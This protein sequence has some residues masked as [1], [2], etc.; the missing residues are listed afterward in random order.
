MNEELL[1]GDP[2]VDIGHIILQKVVAEK[3]YGKTQSE[4]PE[5]L[6]ALDW[7][8]GLYIN[9]WQKKLH[10]FF[11]NSG[12][13]NPSNSGKE[14]EK[15]KAEYERYFRKQTPDA[16]GICR[17]AGKE[18]A[19]YA[20][21][22]E[23][24]ILSG[25]GAFINFHHSLEGGLMTGGEALFATFFTPLGCVQAGD[26][27]ALI[28]SNR[29][30]VTAYLAAENYKLNTNPAL[31]GLEPGLAKV[32]AGNPAN[33]I[34]EYADKINLEK[35]RFG[36]AEDS[37]VALTLYHFTNF[38]AKPEVV[39][40]NLSATL[41]SFYHVVTT[42]PEFQKEWNFFVRDHYRNSKF[43]GAKA[44][45]DNET[46]LVPG[47]EGATEKVARDTY[48]GWYNDV[49]RNLIANQNL[50]PL[51][52]RWTQ[53]RGF[54]LPFKIISYYCKKILFMEQQTLNLI[55]RLAKHLAE[56]DESQV[57]KTLNRLKLARNEAGVRTLL[58]NTQFRH[59]KV[60]QKNDEDSVNG[61]DAEP[62]IRLEEYVRYLFPESG[63][64]RRIKDL[65]LI[66]I[67]EQL[68]DLGKAIPVLD[69]ETEKDSYGNDGE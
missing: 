44:T 43:K 65:L 67:Y 37:A 33:A 45:A 16:R 17:V 24:V 2:F 58:L 8:S 26:K 53:K 21:G 46:L 68:H 63:D 19:L 48:Q 18:D 42:Y 38:G 29:A 22:R 12:I 10:G 5:E 30:D 3:P 27:I 14:A 4:Q 54:I 49:Y 55:E 36:I 7:A 31:K 41:F 60:Q 28:H 64:W 69:E 25:S 6:N 32:K 56:Q 57:K 40:Y 39:V 11:Q 34:F 61:K 47:K 13:T 15:T 59:Y 20:A 51:I 62:F 1:S 23:S 50:L 35:T 52:V 66:S 9:G